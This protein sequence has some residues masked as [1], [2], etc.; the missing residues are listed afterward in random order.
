MGFWIIVG[1][2]FGA[3]RVHDRGSN[4]PLSILTGALLGP[5]AFVLLFIPGS[6]RRCTH[7][8]EWVRNSAQA[9]PHCRQA[10]GANGPDPP[11]TLGE[12]KARGL[13][14]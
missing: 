11:L 13:I 12:M 5:L 2:L 9:C 7:C 14:R 3:M 4:V 8:G 1:A 10:V 6:R